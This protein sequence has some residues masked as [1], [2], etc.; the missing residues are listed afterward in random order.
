MW[1]WNVQW[2]VPGLAR[3]VAGIAWNFQ[4]APGR[5]A[6]GFELA[7]K[8]DGMAW[9]VQI[10]LGRF[11]FGFESEG[12]SYGFGIFNGMFRVWLERLMASWLGL[13]KFF[14]EGSHHGW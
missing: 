11:T 10:S 2:N 1:L 6:F 5:F 4:I 7:R 3:K 9:N 12:R 14:L 8:V 13:F